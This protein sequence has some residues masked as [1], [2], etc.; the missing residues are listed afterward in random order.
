MMPDTE[1]DTIDVTLKLDPQVHEF[2]SKKARKAGVGLETYL[3]ST[4]SL[5]LGCKAFEQMTGLPH[6]TQHGEKCC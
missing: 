6:K 3:S 2:F 1:H 5:V 4:L